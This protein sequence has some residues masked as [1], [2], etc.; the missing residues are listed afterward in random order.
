MCWQ[1]ESNHLPQECWQ[2]LTEMLTNDNQVMK[3]GW[4]YW[5]IKSKSNVKNLG[6]CDKSMWVAN[7]SRIC[8][9]WLRLKSWQIIVEWWN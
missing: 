7:D 5:Q 4:K 1:N 2:I 6:W 9:T 3:V 8:L